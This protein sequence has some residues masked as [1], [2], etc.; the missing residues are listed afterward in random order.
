M[1]VIRLAA[2]LASAALITA[3]GG[4]ESTVPL[5]APEA[6]VPAA[7]GDSV[8]ALTDFVAQQTTSDTDEPLRLGAVVPATDDTAEPT[9]L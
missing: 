3:C 5:P 8:S 6:S 7:V 2:L 1:F 4:G 9:P